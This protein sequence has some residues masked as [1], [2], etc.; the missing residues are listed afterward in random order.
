MM[1]A[2]SENFILSLS[3]D[4]VVHGKGS[5]INK[6]AL[7]ASILAQNA[8]IGVFSENENLLEDPVKGIFEQE[9]VSAVSIFN[10]EGTPLKKRQKSPVI[11]P[12]KTDGTGVSGG[13]IPGFVEIE[14]GDR[15]GHIPV[16]PLTSITRKTMP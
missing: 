1:Y 9:E 2:F 10:L 11:Q 12:E 13:C 16:L 8:R 14:D 4:E 15:L 6:G 3:H 5:L 7:L